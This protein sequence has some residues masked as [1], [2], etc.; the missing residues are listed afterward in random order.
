MAQSLAPC[1]SVAAYNRHRRNGEEPDA[2][3]KA[4]KAADKRGR[5]AARDVEAAQVVA[6][7]FR[8][9]VDDVDVL[10]EE[11]ENLATVKAAMLS[12]PPQSLAALSK[13]RSELVARIAELESA[14]SGE[15][16]SLADQ[17]AEAAAGMVINLPGTGTN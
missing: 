1:G 12:A 5:R 17:V 3:C 2:A 8:P 10:A 13:R 7:D 6:A 11:R 14:A 16:K 15:R 4:A 9:I